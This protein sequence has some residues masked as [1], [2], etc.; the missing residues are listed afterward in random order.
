[1]LAALVLGLV[2]AAAP[3]CWDVYDGALRH[4]AAASHPAFVSYDEQIRITEDN[5]P[6]VRSRAHVDYRDDGWA[7]VLDERFDFEPIV[8]RHAEP[9]PPEIGPY[10]QS[11]AA[12]LPQDSELPIIADVRSEGAVS[13]TLSE[14]V[15]YKGRV[16]RHLIFSGGQIAERAGVKEMWVDAKTG[17]V[18]KLIVSGPVA[19]A[20]DPGSKTELADFEV[21]LGYVGPYLLVN[22]VTWKYHRRE[23]SQYSSYFA[24]YTLGGYAF[25]AQLPASYFAQKTVARP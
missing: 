22:H 6:L 15:P 20:D 18:W 7:R 4:S 8:T 17:D 2:A 1:M 5:F 25:P 11:R 9:G 3:P 19:F 24:E 12:W 10:G 23:F 14:T 13:C 21:E 16:S